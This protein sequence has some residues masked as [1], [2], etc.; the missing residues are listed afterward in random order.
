METVIELTQE[1]D[2]VEVGSNFDYL[3][4]LLNDNE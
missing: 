1:E 4:D 3:S 2:P